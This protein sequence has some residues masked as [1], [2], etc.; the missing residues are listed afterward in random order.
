ME[1]IVVCYSRVLFKTIIYLLLIANVD[2][3]YFRLQCSLIK[4]QQSIDKIL[5]CQTID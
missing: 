4:S 1:V 3:I 5:E 2:N